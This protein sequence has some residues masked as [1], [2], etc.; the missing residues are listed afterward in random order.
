MIRLFYC[1]IYD[2]ENSSLYEPSCMCD[3]VCMFALVE[4]DVYC[5]VKYDRYFFDL[6]NLFARCPLPVVYVFN[7]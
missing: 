4:V 1:S 7:K 2:F 5:A 3:C 6:F